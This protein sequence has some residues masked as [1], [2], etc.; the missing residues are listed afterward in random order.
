MFRQIEDLKSSAKSRSQGITELL[1]HIQDD[2]VVRE[3]YEVRKLRHR[4]GCEIQRLERQFPMAT[5][6]SPSHLAAIDHS[7]NEKLLLSDPAIMPTRS[8]LIP[9]NHCV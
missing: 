3:I 4:K 7:D 8:N 2:Q 1:C 6:E 5:L 9:L